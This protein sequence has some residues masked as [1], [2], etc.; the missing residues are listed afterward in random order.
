MASW[1]LLFMITFQLFR[2]YDQLVA[3]LNDNFSL[4]VFLVPGNKIIKIYLELFVFGLV[5]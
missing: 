4:G 1:Q 5:E 2:V 3:A